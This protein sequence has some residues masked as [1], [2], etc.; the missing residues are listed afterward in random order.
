[1]LEEI[2]EKGLLHRVVHV[3]VEDEKG[4]ILLQFRG[5]NVVTNPNT[6]DFATAGYVDPGESYK[7]TALRELAE[8]LGLRGFN[9]QSLGVIREKEVI[10]DRE[11]NRFAGTFKAIVP[12][13]TTFTLQE[14]EVAKVK[15]F[16][17]DEIKQLIANNS[18]EV[19]PYFRQWL[20]EHYFSHE[21]NSY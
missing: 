20:Q 4:N 7:Q 18:D 12:A 16:N 1:M 14:S 3:L 2:L 17:P 21:N 6:W 15:W 9:L 10:N 11:V 5:P 8:E 13:G 19:T